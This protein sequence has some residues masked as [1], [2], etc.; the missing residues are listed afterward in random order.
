MIETTIR[1]YFVLTAL[2]RFGVG[3]IM[4][5]Y[6]MYLMEK[7]LTL[8]EVNLVNCAYFATLFICEIPTGAIADVFGRKMSY[9][10]SCVLYGIGMLVYGISDSFFGFIAAEMIC[11]VGSTCATGA[12]QGWFV[13]SLRHYGYTGRTTRLLS[14]EHMI[15]QAASIAGAVMGPFLLGISAGLPWIV[16]GMI[17]LVAA[18]LST[19]WMKEEYFTRGTLS[20]RDRLLKM[21]AVTRTS[22]RYVRSE[23]NFRFVICLGIAQLIAIKSP[24]MQWQP[25]FST[26]FGTP[27]LLGILWAG[28]IA[29]SIAG[30]WLAPCFLSLVHGN[31]RWALV[32][33]NI[34]IGVGI[35]ATILFNLPFGLAAFLLHEAA[36]GLWKPLKDSY[37]QDTMPDAERAT[38]ASFESMFTHHLGGLLGLLLGGLLVK[39]TSI[40][41]T[42]TVVSVVLIAATLTVARKR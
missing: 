1:Q 38:I 31:E 21:K 35:V 14:R 22:M 37:L 24:D 16:G 7:G 30:A 34:G 33:A 28:I 42:W 3:F 39:Y 13:S 23:Q 17:H 5:I 15:G 27:A 25:F 18:V 41:T 11:A 6:T 12:F 4:A 19:Y 8:F 26:A 2:S 36:R 10:L 32:V 9:V 29:A 20:L 40:P